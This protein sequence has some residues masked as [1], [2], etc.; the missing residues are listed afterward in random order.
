MV[1]NARSQVFAAKLPKD[2]VAQLSQICAALGM[3]KNFL[4]EEALREKIED[5]MDSY[6]LR[7]AMKQATGF[8]SWDA[9]LKEIKKA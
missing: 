7:Q 8:H 1:M 6:D 3:R 2:L 5:L 4:V 9:V